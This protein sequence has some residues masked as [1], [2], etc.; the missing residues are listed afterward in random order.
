MY[1]GVRPLR[2]LNTARHCCH[3]VVQVGDI[4]QH[5]RATSHSSYLQSGLHVNGK[6]DQ[7]VQVAP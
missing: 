6:I 7:D 3:L 5:G 1:V 4:I 2:C